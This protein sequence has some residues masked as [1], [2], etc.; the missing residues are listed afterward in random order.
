MSR[1][2]EKN[3]DQTF[4]LWSDIVRAQG[5]IPRGMRLVLTHGSKTYGIAFRQHLTGDD[6]GNSKFGTGHYR[7]YVGDDYLG[8]T[9]TE[10]WQTLSTMISVA[11]DIK[12]LNEARF[13]P[14]A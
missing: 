13:E 10:A 5:G 4:A 3:L 2:T 6:S 9:K 8:M 1:I 7:P 14:I 12:H 11:R